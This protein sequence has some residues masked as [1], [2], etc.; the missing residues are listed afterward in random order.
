MVLELGSRYLRA[1]FAGDAVPKAVINFGPEE[2]R[3]AGDYRR[4][5]TDY[6]N[7]AGKCLQGQSW[8][9]AWEL[10][11]M[12]LRGLDLGLV[13]D[14][15]D[16][17][18]RDAF[19]RL[20][21]ECLVMELRLIVVL[22][23]FLLIDS[24]PRRLILA[25]PSTLPL[26]L[27][28]TILDT[29]FNSFQPPNI[30][31]L[32]APILTTVAAGLRSALVVD[33]GWAE[34]VVTAVYEYR[35]VQCRRSVRGTK[36]LGEAMYEKLVQ[37]IDPTLKGKLAE[38]RSE[39]ENKR[40][41]SFQECEE[42]VARISWSKPAKKT[43]QGRSDRGLTPVREEDEFRS[44]MRM[45]NMSEQ[46]GQDSTVSIQLASTEPPRTLKLPLSEI[47][48]PCETALFAAGTIETD[49][50]DEELPLHLLVYRSLLLLPVDVRSICMSRIVF[51]G[52]GSSILG[53]K[54]RILD[55][56]ATLIDER[57]WDP[58]RGKAV[59]QY[60]NNPKLQRTKARQDGPTEVLQQKDANG[61]EIIPAA[62][63][64]QESDPI[65]EQLKREASKGVP[66]VESGN[67]RGVNSL[68]AWS[69]ASLLTQLKIPAI[70]IID[71]EQWLQHGAAGATKS[72]EIDLTS[73]RQSM[74]PGA[75]FK[76]GA[77]DRSSWTLGL[78]G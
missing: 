76:S 49:L 57:T 46:S 20:V 40:L 63:Q 23:R 3:R 26:P 32:S 53:L 25:I 67:L 60:R 34:T 10:W 9:E 74:G 62:I 55:E 8:G 11:K 73:R 44:S 61:V 5:R 39:R 21:N 2:Q 15:L 4:W 65:E 51:V 45:M 6:D 59:E 72:T 7:S 37:A 28:S 1:G 54:A 42:V 52:G 47:A 77:G 43:E 70:S 58:V 27:L 12:D 50:D 24:R 30:S 19:T 36:M 31:L 17:A 13:G 18:V 68:G 16:R 69:G 64:E 75:S 22:C 71:R 78:W 66:P 33:I 14:K 38:K 56:V 29:L 35:E 41:P 48:E